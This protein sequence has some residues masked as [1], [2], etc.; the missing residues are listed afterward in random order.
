M[1]AVIKTGGKQYRV[2]EGDVVNIEKIEGDT[3]ANVA[4][5]EVL[6]VS[7]EAE[8]KIGTPFLDGASV[9]GT[10]L[11]QGRSKKLIVFKFKRR[12]DYK[13][14]YGHR[15]SFTRIRIDQIQA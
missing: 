10:I 12:K 14:K 11:E 6:M 13:R 5:E 8:T 4:F 2:A 15:Q 3:G 1:Y 7:Q 9:S